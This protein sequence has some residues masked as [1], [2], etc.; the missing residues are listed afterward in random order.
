MLPSVGKHASQDEQT[1]KSAL[2]NML[3][4]TSNVASQQKQHVAQTG[5]KLRAL[6]NENKI[7]LVYHDGEHPGH[8]V[9]GTESLGN[10]GYALY[11]DPL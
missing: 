9:N 5:L 11:Y 2:A 8:D 3:L 7:K 6:A 10:R 1:V 4:S